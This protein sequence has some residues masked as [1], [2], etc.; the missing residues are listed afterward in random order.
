MSLP[1]G[2]RDWRACTLARAADLA[3]KDEAT[4]EATARAWGLDRVRHHRTRFTPPF[5]LQDTQAYTIASNEMIIT[6]FRGTEHAQIRDWLSDVATPPRPGPAS[7]GYIHYGFGEA[8]DS[9]FPAVEAAL[10]EFRDNDQSVWF[11]GH[12]L[13]G[14]LAMLAGCRIYLEAPRLQA[15]G[16]YTFGQPRTCDRLLAA[17]CN[18]SFKDR[19]HRYV[20]NNDVVPQL[21]PEPVYTHVDT[22]HYIDSTGCI[23]S[24]MP[25]LATLGDRLK[26]ATADL[27]APVGDGLRDHSITRYITAMEKNLI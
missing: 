20:N 12:S 10:R 5:P 27:L 3:Y 7:T 2:R 23:R 9:V 17:S 8:L 11:T 16:I 13:G 22:L 4:V 15:D 14:A 1:P 18:K 26:G 24:A 19:L 21:P 25:A 6:G